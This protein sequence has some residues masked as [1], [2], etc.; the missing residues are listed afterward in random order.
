MKVFHA[1]GVAALLAL[2]A[3]AVASAGAPA[4]V[5]PQNWSFQD[6]LTWNDYKPLPGKDYS[7]PAIEPTV[8]KW[9]VALVLT[10]FDD[11][12]YYVTQP[13]GST[14]YGTP[15]LEAHDIPREQVASWYRDFLNKPQPIN[16][17]Q[18]M[19]RYWMEDSFGKYGVQ[20]DA[21]GPYQLPGRQYQYFLNDQASNNARCP[22]A[23][24]TP[25]NRNFRTDARAAW[26][27]TGPGQ[28]STAE[29]A[30]YDNVFYVSAGED[31]S[32][33]WQEFGEMKWMTP[34]EVTD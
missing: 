33:T 10:D 15:T 21:F 4:P 14:I 8:K 6:N 30:T 17:F 31:E 27:G 19:N 29:A 16:H 25:C 28:I 2:A 34:E 18:T 3:P 26:V 7:D 5:D 9:K 20:L 22:T 13:A 12:P 24:T 11:K 23:A 1:A 32:S